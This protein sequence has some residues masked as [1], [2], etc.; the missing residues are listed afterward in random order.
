MGSNAGKSGWTKIGQSAIWGSGVK[1]KIASASCGGSQHET[2][3]RY[4]T[5]GL[6][7]RWN[8]DMKAIPSIAEALRHQ[9]GLKGVR[10]EADNPGPSRRRRTQRLRAP[11]W[12][13]DSDSELENDHRN[14]VPRR[15]DPFVPAD[16]VEAL[17]QDL[18]QP[19]MVPADPNVEVGRQCNEDSGS[20]LVPSLLDVVEQNLAA[21]CTEII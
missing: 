20:G 16:V 3:R 6:L 4:F 9:W 18:C 5:D 14:V 12:V 10:G 8:G 7:D 21:P 17:E 11:P 2:G 13:W 19:A 15:V 1:L